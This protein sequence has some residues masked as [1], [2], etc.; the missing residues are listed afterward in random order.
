MPIS[1]RS[2]LLLLVI[3]ALLPAI[4]GALWV[5][6][7]TFEA[8]RRAMERGLRDSAAALSMVVERELTQRAAIARALSTSA[9]LDDAPS[10]TPGQLAYFDRQAR[11]AMQGLAGWVEIRSADGLLFSTRPAGPFKSS[12]PESSPT[13]LAQT[14]FVTPLEPDP[15]H[16]GWH[17]AVV[18]PVVRGERTV[19]N[20]AVTILPS[21][22]QRI[23]D[24]QQLPQGWLTTVMDGRGVV[25]ARSSGGA[26]FVGRSATPEM[27]QALS[28][29]TEGRFEAMSLDGAEV[30]GYFNTSPQGW[31]FF[32]AMPQSEFGGHVP[33]AVLQLLAGGA[34]LLLLT[35]GGAIWISRRITDPVDALAQMAA[36]MHAGQPVQAQPSGVA[37][38]DKVGDAIAEAARSMHGA[39]AEL[40]RRVEEAIAR[41]RDAEQRVSQSQRVEA[42]GRLTGGVAHDVNNLLGVISNSAYLIERHTQHQPELQGPLAATMRAVDAGRRLSQHLLRFAG[43]HATRPERIDLALALPEMRELLSIVLGKRIVVEVKVAPGTSRIVVDAGEL[44]LALIN[45]ALNA[46]DALQQPGPQ[47]AH[48]WLEAANAGP[49]ELAELAPGPYVMITFTDD[50]KGL[51]DATASRAFE[52]F[53]TTKPAGLGSGL[54]LS[55]VHGFCT[56][57]GGRASIASTPGLGTTVS[58]LLPADEMQAV[59]PTPAAP[60][61]RSAQPD[62]AGM[63]VLLVEDNES[64][65]DV[66]AALLGSYGCSVRL[67]RSAE[68]ALAFIDD[69]DDFDAVLSDIVMPG[70]MDGIALGQTLKARQPELPVV[71]ISGYS[72][73][74]VPRDQFT[75]LHKPCSPQDLVGALRAA[76]APRA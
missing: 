57:A 10:V 59:A 1:I 26:A 75:V 42:L 8:E 58:L 19:A 67:A 40:E 52:P 45:L 12:A 4:A 54:G 50:G 18:Q 51:D 49:A 15:G 22:L 66:T 69:G 47:G 41:T 43:R 30:A 55:Q 13:E 24:Q 28:S 76:A 3:S 34:V 9:M 62:L 17:A 39:H 48:V 70:G 44:E 31:T 37:E 25:V 14:A 20:L 72:S 46:R 2:R 53:F 61:G 6:A 5:I 33:A 71:L 64:L 23:V 60:A 65:G 38:F 7:N 74:R 16:R 29:R 36:R 32:T 68:Q 35:V 63:R 56:E 21:E 27:R 11:M 73:E